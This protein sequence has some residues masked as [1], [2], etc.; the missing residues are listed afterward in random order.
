MQEENTRLTQELKA[1][2]ERHREALEAKRTAQEAC[3]D[4]EHS[5]NRLHTVYNKKSQEFNELKAM[6]NDPSRLQCTSLLCCL[7]TVLEHE[8]AHWMES[9]QHVQEQ[10]MRERQRCDYYRSSV[11]KQPVLLNTTDTG[12]APVQL[13][14][15]R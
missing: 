9:M 1:L 5:L 14:L 2:D 11:V 7:Q 13:L 15:H 8:R 10:L 6:I 3:S 12:G 4:N